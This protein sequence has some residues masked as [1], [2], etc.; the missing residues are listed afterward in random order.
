MYFHYF[1]IISPWNRTGPFI[2]TNLNPLHPRMHC[3]KFGWNWPCGSGEEDFFLMYFRYFLI[4]FPWKRTGSFIWTKLILL[5]PRMLCAEFA[6]N[7][8][9]GSGEWKVYDNANNDNDGQWTNCD[10]KISLNKIKIFHSQGQKHLIQLSYGVDAVIQDFWKHLN[11]HCSQWWMIIFF[12][13]QEEIN[14]KINFLKSTS[15]N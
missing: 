8:L 5:H 14:S 12:F 15:W 6:W 13:N 10:Q 2:S 9:K 7:W 1:I 11:L 4:I 3:A